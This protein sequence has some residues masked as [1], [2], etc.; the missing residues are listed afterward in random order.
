MATQQQLERALMKLK[1]GLK[2][3][4][5]EMRDLTNA[6]KQAGDFGNRVRAA[7]NGK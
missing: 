1:A 2:L 3:T 5:Q 4:D 7:L 6:A